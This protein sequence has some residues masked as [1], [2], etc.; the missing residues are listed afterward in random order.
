MVTNFL[1]DLFNALGVGLFFILLPYS[2]GRLVLPRGEA[3]KGLVYIVGMFAAFAVF[4]LVYL[5]FF[6]LKKD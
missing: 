5:P 1:I 4:E 3:D 2:A 6:F